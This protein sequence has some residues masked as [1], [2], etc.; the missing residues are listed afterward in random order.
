MNRTS[1]M[2]WR[3]SKD[4]KA[5]RRKKDLGNFS[6]GMGS[7]GCFLDSL[8]FLFRSAR[9][10][11]LEDLHRHHPVAE[12]EHVAQAPARRDESG[13]VGLHVESQ[14]IKDRSAHGE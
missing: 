13:A 12:L 7:P 11:G 6:S 4:S 3:P 8:A 10:R 9:P 5:L 14:A 1:T 2:G